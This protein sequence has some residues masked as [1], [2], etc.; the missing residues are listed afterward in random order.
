MFH[1]RFIKI[2]CWPH[3]DVG[4]QWYNQFRLGMFRNQCETS[5]DVCSVIYLQLIEGRL[6]KQANKFLWGDHLL[7]SLDNPWV[8]VY[9]FETIE[10]PAH[11][12][13]WYV[14]DTSIDLYLAWI[15]QSPR[16]DVHVFVR[17]VEC[18]VSSRQATQ[19]CLPILKGLASRRPRHIIH[20]LELL[21]S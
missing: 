7:K 18:H 4:L 21:Q 6:V 13:C 15:Y 16:N 5:R 14:I 8:V 9:V 1:D 19:C 3:V 10:G 11:D 17:Q 20:P 2:S 12:T